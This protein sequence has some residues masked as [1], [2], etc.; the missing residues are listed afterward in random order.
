MF[1][2]RLMSLASLPLLREAQH[3]RVSENRSVKS[4]LSI[5]CHAVPERRNANVLSCY[6]EHTNTV[7]ALCAGCMTCTV[8]EA[9]AKSLKGK[10]A[11]RGILPERVAS[12]CRLLRLPPGRRCGAS[13]W[14][15]VSTAVAITT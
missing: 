11:E 6:C 4:T 7:G 1:I 14:I 5:F 12:H 13:A 10:C 9:D 3:I 8:V 15:A 2:L